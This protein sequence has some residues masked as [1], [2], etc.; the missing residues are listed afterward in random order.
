MKLLFS[1]LLLTTSL[2]SV[3]QVRVAVFAGPQTT[4]AKYTVNDKKQPTEYKYGFNVG[5]N[6][7]VPVEGPLYFAPAIYY[8]LLG[9][10]VTLN[11]PS[12]PPDPRAVNNN[13][14]I[15]TVEV[16]PL[17]NFDLSKNP[18]HVF[19]QVGPALNF[20]IS[21]KEEFTRVENGNTSVVNQKMTF[22]T[23]AYGTITSSAVARIGYEAKGGLLFFAHYAHGLGSAN[24]ADLGPQI[25][26]RVIGLSIGKYL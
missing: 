22:K 26:H 10:K 21:G 24:N 11:N 20:A 2:F 16:A 23:T 17:L 3:A 15:H 19:I 5:A 9:Y 14:T 12:F 4:T 25:K 7:K 8:S 6:L 1:V 18:G 13:T